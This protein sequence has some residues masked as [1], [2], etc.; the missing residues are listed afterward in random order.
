MLLIQG[1]LSSSKITVNIYNEKKS[2]I[3]LAYYQKNEKGRGKKMQ[4]GLKIVSRSFWLR[5]ALFLLL[6]TACHFF[7]NTLYMSNVLSVYRI[8][9]KLNLF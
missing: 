4:V 7:E 5:L 6:T 8:E 3:K 2:L 9:S 1:G